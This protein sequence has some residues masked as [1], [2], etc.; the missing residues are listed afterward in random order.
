[1]TGATG[2]VGRA[3]TQIAHW[4]G[5]RVIGADI[6]ERPG[7]AD[8]VVNLNRED[9]VAAV[10]SA[11]RDEGVDL[12]FDAVGGS[13]FESALKSLRPHGRQ[14]AISSMGERRVS[15][16]LIDFYH[17]GLRLL[18]VDSLKLDGPQIAAIMNALKPGF[19]SGQLKPYEVREWSL[20]DAAHA[21]S[22]VEKGAG[23]VK[24]VLVAG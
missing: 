22:V 20:D 14:V 9:L 10:K 8:V 6:V 24:Q 5:A 23:P 18:G 15:F 12:V 2:A 17:Q 13:L 21:Y 7:P 16:D 3:V 19:E 1:V 11:T 4:R